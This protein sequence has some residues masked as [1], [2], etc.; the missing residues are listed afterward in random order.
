MTA[1]TPQL[2]LA[3]MPRAEDALYEAMQAAEY[4]AAVDSALFQAGIH[5]IENGHNYPD[6]E[7]K[8]IGYDLALQA[9]GLAPVV[10]ND[11][12]APAAEGLS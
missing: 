12:A 7:M 9:L 3:E 6:P 1:Y 8:R 4:A 2:D 11:Q 10:L 5:L